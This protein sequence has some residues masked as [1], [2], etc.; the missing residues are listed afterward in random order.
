MPTLNDFGDAGVARVEKVLQDFAAKLGVDKEYA[1][2]YFNHTG[3]LPQTLQEFQTFLNDPSNNPYNFARRDAATGALRGYLHPGDTPGTLGAKDPGFRHVITNAEDTAVQ[4][5]QQVDASGNIFGGSWDPAYNAAHPELAGRPADAGFGDDPNLRQRI[6]ASGSFGDPNNH[7]GQDGQGWW[8]VV[9]GRRIGPFLSRQ[10][11]EQAYN[12]NGGP[13]PGGTGA[14]GPPASGGPPPAPAPAGA[15]PG[16]P[17][18]SPPGGG[19]PG[20]SPSGTGTLVSPTAIDAARAVADA[21]A[22]RAYLNARLRELEIPEMQARTEAEKER[23]RLEAARDAWTKE[24]QTATLTGKTS[25][26]QPIL[27][28]AKAIGVIGGVNTVDRDRLTGEQTGY[29]GQGYAASAQ[30]AWDKLPPEQRTGDAAA[31]IWQNVVPGLSPQEAAAMNEAGHQYY[32]ATGQVMPDSV[33]AQHLARVTGGRVTGTGAAPTLDREREQN[34]TTIDALTMLANLRGPE[35]AFAYA[36]TLANI[37]DS[38]RANIQAAMGRLPVTARNPA[39]AGLLGDV[40]ALGQPTQ[41]GTP[42]LVG[43]GA[44]MSGSAPGQPFVQGTADPTQTGQPALAA[45]F[46]PRTGPTRQ[47]AVMPQDQ[48]I[49]IGDFEQRQLGPTSG[50]PAWAGGQQTGQVMPM[51][52][53]QIAP[54]PGQGQTAQVMPMRG[55][56]IAPGPTQVGRPALVAAPGVGQPPPAFGPRTQPAALPSSSQWSPT[57]WNNTNV[58]AQK[59]ML[60]GYE[61]AGQDKEAVMDAYRKSLPRAFGPRTGRL[62]A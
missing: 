59:L 7:T 31:R 1:Y 53:P 33:A 46:G 49:G 62:A 37:P 10:E 15:A 22:Q 11:A 44:T 18:G 55:P 17:S 36:N 19:Y 35:N 21:A 16:A 4:R 8:A 5:F 40:G 2:A 3:H 14:G 39:Q 38:I 9:D 43:G 48:R 29:T 25:D 58:Y 50:V 60:A 13:P 34:R 20:G 28:A 51:R 52:G 30:A 32:A 42:A 26:G 56:Q 45:A 57:D 6:A 12:A 27:D 47:A 61:N 24:Y 41:A 54:T 23:L